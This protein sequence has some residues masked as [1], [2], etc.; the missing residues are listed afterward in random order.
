MDTFVH[1]RGLIFSAKGA[2]PTTPYSLLGAKLEPSATTCQLPY[3][4]ISLHQGASQGVFARWGHSHVCSCTNFVPSQSSLIPPLSGHI[5]KGAGNTS[6]SKLV[7]GSSKRSF[8]REYLQLN[9]S[10]NNE[11]LS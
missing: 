4:N 1:V 5:R 6:A 7:N 11:K 8:Y 2:C 3:T 10:D 9:D